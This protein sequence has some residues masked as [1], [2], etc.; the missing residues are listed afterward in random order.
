MAVI[1]E[2]KYDIYL[3]KI[4]LIIRLN[5]SQSNYQMIINMMSI[6]PQNEITRLSDG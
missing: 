1:T 5:M 4:A 2:F 6:H 3:N